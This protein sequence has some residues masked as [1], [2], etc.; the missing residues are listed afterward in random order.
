MAAGS[1][2]VPY[3]AERTSVVTGTLTLLGRVLFAGI[4]LMFGPPHFM[5]QMIGYAA[6]QG[7]PLASNSRT[8]LARIRTRTRVSILLGYRAKIWRMADWKVLP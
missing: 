5:K 2:A 3:R 6:S 4:F 1:T 7:V 8:P